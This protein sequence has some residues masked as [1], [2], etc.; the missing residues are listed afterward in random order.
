MCPALFLTCI[1]C[2]AR[3]RPRFILLFAA[4]PP[5]PT[6]SSLGPFYSSLSI[7]S[8]LEPLRGFECFFFLLSSSFFHA[9]NRLLFPTNA[10]HTLDAERGEREK[11]A[12]DEVD[13]LLNFLCSPVSHYSRF[14]MCT[15]STLTSPSSPLLLS[16]F[17]FSY[18]YLIFSLLFSRPR[19]AV[20]GMAP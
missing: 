18:L 20:L 3:P 9:T 11:D 1:S 12:G 17:T 10:R 5:F 13:W 4:A 19:S 8:T 2:H 6:L 16:S 14:T 7:L 15:P